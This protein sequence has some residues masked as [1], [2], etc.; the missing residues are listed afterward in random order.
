MV[1]KLHFHFIA[2]GVHLFKWH[3]PTYGRRGAV[4]RH[5]N[6]EDWQEEEEKEDAP[7]PLQ[8]LFIV[9]G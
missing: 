1:S 2:I 3:V 4:M 9:R 5:P 6:T 7:I 8:R